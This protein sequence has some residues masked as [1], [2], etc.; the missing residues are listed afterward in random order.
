MALFD[1]IDGIGGNDVMFGSGGRDILFGQR[2]DDEMHGGADDDELIGGLGDDEMYG[3][4]GRDF[5]LGDQGYFVRALNAD[6]SARINTDGAFHRDAVLEDVGTITG[7]IPLDTTAL[8]TF[9]PQLAAKITMADLVLLSGTQNPDGTK[10]TQRRQRRVAD[11]GAADRPR[12]RQ[13]RHDLR[14]RR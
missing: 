3:D 9:D 2:G 4:G 14:R 1:V 7:M 10:Y 13:Q 11:R 12:G 6:G 5:M 8:R